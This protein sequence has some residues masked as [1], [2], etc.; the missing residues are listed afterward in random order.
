MKI[1]K[2]GN[3]KNF[4]PDMRSVVVENKNKNRELFIEKCYN[5]SDWK[6]ICQYDQLS[7]EFILRNLNKIDWK[8]I[9][10]YQ[11]LS[12]RFIIKHKNNAIWKS[13]SQRQQEQLSG[14]YYKSM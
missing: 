1:G 2:S 9:F 10:Q 5:N 6:Y 11:K 8:L 13:I 14:Q 4:D 12:E 3:F 7:E